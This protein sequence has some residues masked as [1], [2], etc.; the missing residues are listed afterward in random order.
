MA[1]ISELPTIANPR[2]DERVPVVDSSGGTRAVSIQPLVEAAVAPSLA[3]AES[4]AGFAEEFSG[5]AHPSV[6]EGQAATSN[7]QF[8]RVWDGVESGDRQYIRYE[9]TPDG[10]KVAAPLAPA[11]ALA[12][13]NQVL[14]S[15]R[16]V[17]FEG[18]G[19]GSRQRTMDDKAAERT[20]VK[21]YGAIGDGT[22]HTVAEWIG[23][24][25]I[26]PNLAALQAVYPHVYSASNSIDWA[27]T[28]QAVNKVI[29]G[30]LKKEVFVP[31]GRYMMGGDTLHLGYGTSFRSVAIVGEGQAYRGQANFCGTTL[32]FSAS[33]RMAINVQGMRMPRIRK[34]TIEGPLSNWIETNRLADSFPRDP[35]LDD[36]LSANW[37]DPSLAATQDSRYAPLAGI[38]VDGYAG[39]RPGV[40]YPDV[41]YPDFLGAVGQYNKSF[42]KN[43]I[44]EDVM[45]RGFT[46]GV[47]VQPCDADGNG[48]YTV[49]NNATFEFC[50]WGISVGNAQSRNIGIYD[51]QLFSCFKAL[52]N[53]KHG[54]QVGK[55]GGT[56]ANLSTVACIA[57]YE[58]GSSF[59]GPIVF[60]NFYAELL[61]RIGDIATTNT[62]EMPISI[63]GG[64]M[65]FNFHT[66]YR[67]HPANVHGGA[68]TNQAMLSCSDTHFAFFESVAAFLLNGVSLDRCTFTPSSVRTKAYEKFAHN[69]LSGGLSTYQLAPLV[70]ANIKARAFNLDNS[71]AVNRISHNKHWKWGS[72]SMCI[73]HA[74]ET[75]GAEAEMFDKVISPVPSFRGAVGKA[76]LAALSLVDR[77][78]TIQFASRSDGAFMQYG[79]LP[80]D[81]IQD[82]DTGMTFFVRSRTG[83]TVV[84]E[85]QNN[86]KS[87]G[88]GG[89]NT[90]VPFS[91]T[92]GTLYFASSRIYTP[93][94]YL[95]GDT[96]AG[97][98]IITNCGRDDSF[99]AW[100][101]AA[102]AVGDAIALVDTQDLWVS[103][104]AAP[105]VARDQAAGTITLTSSA[106]MR[107]QTRKRLAL[108]CRPG[109]A[110]EASR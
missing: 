57:I 92:A 14:V 47:A 21:D 106:G 59:Y 32:F 88:A 36:T 102:T 40:H 81:V 103:V 58:F 46:V 22:L 85:A 80:G 90:V 62:Q 56:I 104:S 82:G 3:R 29:Y 72:R 23:V 101:D 53:N 60:T 110:N 24:P 89:W 35:L 70:S 91:T 51:V 54:R 30:D 65:K 37:N 52:T 5:V 26:Y 49:I 12:S 50:K 97:S 39:P 20:S 63:I 98:A 44:L 17:G 68:G 83:T 13:G 66:D 55:F 7:G 1:K 105:I 76:S 41:A 67:G 75:F 87:N 61:W 86:Y 94:Y 38:C 48:D 11:A 2:G 74:A 15:G 77:V 84:A 33:D 43:L 8:F 19:P 25:G 27:A 93:P 73:P 109:P 42:T 95:R 28:Q 31:A 45:I 64:E 78:L 69:A 18:S 79:P 107:T 100:Y 6:A 16:A 71:G 96:A 4:S 108:F 34:M 10:P 99:T 9:H